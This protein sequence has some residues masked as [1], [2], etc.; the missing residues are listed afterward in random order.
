MS[1][2]E[3]PRRLSD[4]TREL[5]AQ[6]LDGAWGRALVDLPLSIEGRADLAGASPWR[7]Y[8]ECVKVI[9]E[10]APIRV[11]PGE[12][13]VGAAT[14]LKAS[15]HATPVYEAAGK[16]AFPSISH[17]TLGLDH[18]LAVGYRG[19]RQEVKDR[20]AR[21]GLDE[22]GVELL[23][24]MRICIDA[25]GA[26]QHRYLALLDER[27]NASR[28]AEREAYVRARAN[29]R[30]VPEHPPTTFGEAVQALCLLFVFQRHCGNWPGI[31]RI[32][33]MLGPYL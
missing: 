26:W 20:L 14:L 24:A 8:A 5:A 16:I 27:V 1:L 11:L 7:R 12:R 15:Q 2:V 25:A 19:L 18:A 23:K 9:A 10:Q 22:Q 3:P 17:L 4:R 21:G 30:T 31:G 29:L 6:A 28:G 13:V 32:D 33:A